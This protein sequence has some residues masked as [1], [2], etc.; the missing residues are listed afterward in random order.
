M[1]FMRLAPSP[2]HV[3]TW[4]Y[5]FMILEKPRARVWTIGHSRHELGDFIQ[6]LHVNEISALVDVRSIP[7]SRMAPQF[8]EGSLKKA[9]SAAG[10][11]YISMGKEL[12][13]MLYPM[14]YSGTQ[15]GT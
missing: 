1:N 9:L 7:M 6:K 8:N 10:I 2:F 11:T 14:S 12:G 5:I 15:V 13:G 3:I 4:N